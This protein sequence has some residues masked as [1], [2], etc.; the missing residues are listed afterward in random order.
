LHKESFS[1]VLFALLELT[2]DLIEQILK[3]G[4]RSQIQFLFLVKLD[5]FLLLHSDDKQL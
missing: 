5:T 4:N 1:L 2:E 3:E